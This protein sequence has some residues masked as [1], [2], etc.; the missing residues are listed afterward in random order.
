MKKLPIKIQRTVHNLGD[1]VQLVSS[2]SRSQSET[3]AA[4]AD[5]LQRGRI[6]F[7]SRGQK[8][9]ARIF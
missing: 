9:R 3:V 5:L 4:V 1:L 2:C 7:Q 8:V 6:Q